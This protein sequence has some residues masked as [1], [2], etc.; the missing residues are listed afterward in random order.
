[1][2]GL[3]CKPVSGTI[4]LVTQSTQ[5]ISSI[6][7]TMYISLDSLMKRFPKDAEGKKM[8]MFDPANEIFIGEE[9]GQEV[10]LN[11]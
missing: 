10:Y 1:M 7:Q 4:D 6:P 5:G 8:L 3:V 9:Q 2:L 11:K